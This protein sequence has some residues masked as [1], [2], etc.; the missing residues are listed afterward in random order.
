MSPSLSVIVDLSTKQVRGLP[1][2]SL[3]QQHGSHPGIRQAGLPIRW[4]KSRLDCQEYQ[5]QSMHQ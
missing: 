2:L 5:N 4:Q 3:L 1:G